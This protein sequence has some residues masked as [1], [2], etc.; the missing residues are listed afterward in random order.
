M[1]LFIAALLVFGAV[2]AADEDA[3]TREARFYADYVEA[4]PERLGFKPWDLTLFPA[5][6]DIP[7][8]YVI[9][10]HP[11]Y[12]YLYYEFDPFVSG[13]CVYYRDPT[14]FYQYYYDYLFPEEPVPRPYYA[15]EEP[16]KYLGVP[17]YDYEDNQYGYEGERQYDQGYGGEYDEGDYNEGVDPYMG[18]GGD[19]EQGQGY[20]QD[21]DQGYEGEYNDG[22]YPGREY[23]PQ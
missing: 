16:Q 19:Y 8:G 21:Y 11:G 13:L 4:D 2:V 23:A 6:Y 12:N 3:D 14:F 10:C 9:Y 7:F 1:K 17:D 15:E 18:Y 20:D 5:G 22:Y